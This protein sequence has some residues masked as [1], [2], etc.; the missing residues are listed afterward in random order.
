MT[1][2]CGYGWD[3]E[4]MGGY[5]EAL[6]L[7]DIGPK[8]SDPLRSNNS[9]WRGMGVWLDQSSDRGSSWRNVVCYICGIVGSR[10]LK[11]PGT[12]AQY[13]VRCNPTKH[14]A[15]YDQFDQCGE[16]YS[17]LQAVARCV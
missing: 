5:R 12:R 17:R 9:A 13:V 3:A 15:Y 14:A 16:A 7:H 11:P 6:T 8:P 1:A 2:Q 4:E 10:G